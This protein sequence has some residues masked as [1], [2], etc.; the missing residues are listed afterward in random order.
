MDPLGVLVAWIAGYG[1]VGL[2]AIGVAERFVPVLPSYGVLVAIGI[3]AADGLWSVTAA[4]A[5]TVVG[6]LAGCLLLYG[7]ALALGEKK[8][9]HLLDRVGRLAGMSAIRVDST[10]S[11]FRVHQRLLAFGSQLVPTVRLVSP[12][13]AGLFRADAKAFTIATMAGIVIWNT[14]FI[15][16]GHVAAAVAPATSASALAVTVLVLLIATEVIAGLAW[17]GLRRRSSENMPR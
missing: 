1:I 12:V 6:G 17:R 4:V 10:L 2:V 11:S 3:A 16:V 8:S 13:I 7:I 5:G 14:L 9:Y 15:G